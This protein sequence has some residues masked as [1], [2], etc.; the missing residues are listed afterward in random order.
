MMNDI[1][2]A[3]KTTTECNGIC[4]N[5][6]VRVWM[7]ADPGWHAS[8]GDIDRFINFS[9]RSGYT[10]NIVNL[11]GGEPLLWHNLIEGCRMLKQSGL[12]KELCLYTNALLC[13]TL[14]GLG[15]LEQIIEDL[16]YVRMSLYHGNEEDIEMCMSR[17][18]PENKI[19]VSEQ[20]NRPVPPLHPIENSLPAR[21]H[22]AGYALDHSRVFICGPAPTLIFA[23]GLSFD[24]Y[25]YM[26][27][28]LRDN[29]LD[30][31]SAVDI[32]NQELCR[33]C[34]GNTK[35][36]EVVPA[37]PCVIKKREMQHEPV[38]TESIKAA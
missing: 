37:V 11:T 4:N 23:H 14:K 28:D 3:I 38:G 15:V 24:D 21:C 33:Y 34:I 18:F 13:N 27:D 16:D 32:Y 19:R 9:I 1:N 22:C 30:R 10:Y 6:S 17:G 36:T 26:M 8:L 2:M 7:D 29:F 31:L 20:R 5:C 35:V 12:I 25:A